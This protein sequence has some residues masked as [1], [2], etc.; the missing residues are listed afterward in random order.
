MAIA[1][2]ESNSNE[3]ESYEHNTH[4]VLIG[5]ALASGL[6]EPDNSKIK[7]KFTN[8]QL[9]SISKLEATSSVALL[10]C[11]VYSKIHDTFIDSP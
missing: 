11:P 3:G 2:A 8:V 4:R 10:F 6:N 1:S 7:T 5:E 9:V